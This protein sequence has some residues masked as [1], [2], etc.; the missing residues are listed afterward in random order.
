M[1]RTIRTKINESAYRKL[2][3][4][5][6]RTGHPTFGDLIAYLVR[7]ENKRIDEDRRSRKNSGGG[8][9]PPE[10][11]SSFTNNKKEQ[12]KKSGNYEKD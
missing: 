10:P 8:S 5:K 1:A 3:N 7:Q 12:K 2:K 9:L 6:Q 4:L 11:S